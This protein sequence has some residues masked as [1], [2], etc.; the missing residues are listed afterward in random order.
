MEILTI[1]LSSLVGLASSGG[2]VIDSIAG[3]QISS[4]LN[5]QSQAVRIDNTPSYQITQGKIHKVRIAARDLAIQPQVNIAL[6]ELETDRLH[7]SPQKLSFDSIA[8]FQQALKQPFQGAGRLVV[9][10][11][12]LNL[13]VSSPEILAQLQKILN[14]LIASK[15]GSTNIAYELSEVKI[16]LRSDN[17][18]GVELTLARPLSSFEARGR[19]TANS[20]R[21][22]A[23]S[24]DFKIKILNGKTVSITEPVGTVNG[25]P[26]SPRLLNGFA[27]GISDRLDLADLQTDGILT[28]I[29]QLKIDDDR[30]NLVGF[31]KVE[32]KTT[33]LS[34]RE[35]KAIP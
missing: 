31:L 33:Q 19:A 8:K 14:R 3:K 17:R 18:L 26:M 11:S 10:E 35:V 4:Q 16:K 28:R 12:D 5:S 22:L 20:S 6:L 13:A 25:R 32:T 27:E 24:L 29:L 15:A 30:L 2:V 1:V 21:K 23:M 7:I 34:S 9:T